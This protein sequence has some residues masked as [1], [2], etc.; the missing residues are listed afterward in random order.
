VNAAASDAWNRVTPPKRTPWLD[1]A[2][3]F[4]LLALAGFVLAATISGGPSFGGGSDTPPVGDQEGSADEGGSSGADSSNTDGTSASGSATDSTG[5]GGTTAGPALPVTFQQATAGLEP[6]VEPTA[7]F[8]P[9][10]DPETGRVAIP[11]VYAAPC[12]ANLDGIEAT[13]GHGGVDD[14]T[15]RVVIYQPPPNDLGA[16]LTGVTDSFEDQ[17]ATTAGFVEGFSEFYELWGREVEL[18]PFTGSGLD[19]V[20]AR[21][22]AQRVA[23]EIGAFASLNGPSQQPAYADELAARG[24]LCFACGLGVPDSTFQDLAPHMWGS[25]QTPEQFMVNISDYLFKRVYGRPAIHAGDPSFQT[26]E[27]TFAV[28]HFEQDPP[29]YD[30]VRQILIDRGAEVGWEAEVFLAYEI[31]STMAQRA[32]EIIGQ[33]V[34]R[35]VTT[36]VLMGD[37]V[38]PGFLTVEATAQGYFPEWVITGTVLTDTTVMGRRFDQQQWTNAF[39]ISSIGVP[40]GFDQQEAWLLYEWFNGRDPK[41]QAS[42]RLIFES[43]LQ[44]MTG[45]HLAGP[46]LTPDSFQAALFSYPVSGGTPTAPQI[47]YGSGVFDDPD[48]QGYDDV[49]E[50]WWDAEA[51]GVDEIGAQGTGMMRYANFGQRYAPGEMPETDL[52]VFDPSNSIIG[53]DGIPEQERPKAYPRP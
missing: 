20:S 21:A 51:T 10:C 39:G 2:V 46:E 47:S 40:V 11:T 35:Q 25:L 3:F 28:V 52:T 15:I 1:R 37:P 33:L 42:V 27:R 53:F 26:R 4:G 43:V 22:D 23:D 6:G 49:V 18:I 34:D 29:V 19:E 12:V 14:T 5:G 8:G 45:I 32:R 31:D 16:A 48:Y 7:D 9:N 44:L 13:N 36:V 24:V 30:D 41:A 50:I 17:Q 38:M